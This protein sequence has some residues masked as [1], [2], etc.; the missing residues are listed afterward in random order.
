MSID[1]KKHLKREPQ[2][3]KELELYPIL[4][5][6]IDIYEIF[7]ET[8]CIPKEYIPSREVLRM[9]Y[10]KYVLFFI[11]GYANV[12]VSDNSK[13]QLFKDKLTCLLEYITRQPVNIVQMIDNVS[14][15]DIEFHYEIYIKNKIYYEHDFD[16]IREIILEQNGQSL[17]YIESFNVE[18]E[19]SLK[20]L[21]NSRKG[22]PLTDRVL[23]YSALSHVDISEIAKWT[24]TEFE[25]KEGVLRA[26]EEWRIYR[27][28]EA[29]GQIELKG[30]DKIKS[31]F[32][33]DEKQRDRY[34]SILIRADDFNDNLKQFSK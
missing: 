18:L 5:L 28:L 11:Q 30:K 31:P 16:Q 6:D 4:A 19:E 15:N 32:E 20:I 7:L 14:S 3:Y 29:S 22:T 12:G 34:S 33:I 10:L 23:I 27:P 13:K 21:N 26:Y 2:T 17:E 24:F 25:T 9:S 1:I 8:M